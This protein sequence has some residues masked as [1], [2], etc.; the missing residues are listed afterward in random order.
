MLGTSA[1]SCRRVFLRSSWRSCVP[2]EH[3]TLNTTRVLSYMFTSLSLWTSEC[4]CDLAYN[5]IATAMSRGGRCQSSQ[6]CRG[7][8]RELKTNLHECVATAAALKLLTDEESRLRTCA[9]YACCSQRKFWA[10]CWPSE[11]S[12]DR[13]AMTAVEAVRNIRDQAAFLPNVHIFRRC[14]ADGAQQ[15]P[16]KWRSGCFAK[17]ASGNVARCVH[18]LNAR[19]LTFA[20]PV[21]RPSRQQVDVGVDA[22]HVGTRS[23]TRKM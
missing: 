2:D 4:F 14:S 3:P 12:T 6:D 16:Q 18:V 11:S 13:S 20:T 9:R 10:G 1:L 15:V 7:T 21:P 8:G 19:R 17:A 22:G 5:S 23:S